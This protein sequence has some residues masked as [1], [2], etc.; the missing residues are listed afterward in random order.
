MTSRSSASFS[1]PA[2]K[3]ILDAVTFAATL[4]SKPREIDAQLDRI[5]SITATRSSKKFNDAD[6]QILRE[7]YDY[8]EDYLV[9]K[10]TLRS[11]TRDSVRQRVYDYLNGKRATRLGMPLAVI[12]AIALVGIVGANLL[13]ESI[14]PATIKP[15]LGIASFF[16]TIHLGAAWMFWTGLQNFK[17]KTRWAYLPICAGIILVGITMLQ[18]PLAL[19]IGQ[20]DSLWFRYGSSGIFIT[21]AAGLIYM[22]VRRFA[23]LSGINNKLMSIPIV[24]GICIGTAAI[25][26]ILPRPASDVPGW[27][28]VVSFFILI[29]G[30]VLA[31]ASAALVSVTRRALGVVYRRPMAWFMASLIISGLTFAQFAILQV[32]ATPDNPYE[33]QGFATLPLVVSAFVLLKASTSFRRIDTTIVRD[34]QLVK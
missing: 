12:W 24:A 17:D 13:P 9:E 23:S 30:A 21:I 33:A 31:F 25:I 29:I 8:I 18:V 34:N 14:L 1:L 22:G 2:D 3:T 28:M 16:V 26:S 7:V 10:E 15:V 4:V 32:V 5:R 11:F 19:S 27:V 20:Y 6:T